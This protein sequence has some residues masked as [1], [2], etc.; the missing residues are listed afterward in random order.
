MVHQII[1]LR[2]KVMSN[3]YLV[4][5]DIY[6]LNSPTLVLH[7]YISRYLHI[8]C[9]LIAYF[10]KKKKSWINKTDEK[11]FKKQ[12]NNY[13]RDSSHFFQPCLNIF[14]RTLKLRE[15][16][17]NK[18]EGYHETIQTLSSM[19][20]AECNF[21]MYVMNVIKLDRFFTGAMIWWI[22]FHLLP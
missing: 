17:I 6:H 15:V 16:F 8:Y 5:K 1:L 2:M 10:Q 22:P 11:Y 14:P 7:V 21:V 20:H 18:S 19:L 12:S 13:F 4:T 3:V 9:S